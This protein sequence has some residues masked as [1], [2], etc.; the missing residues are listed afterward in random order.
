MK[1]Y[2]AL[3]LFVRLTLAVAV[4]FFVIRAVLNNWAE[5]RS[6]SWDFNPTFLVLSV[7]VFLGGYIFLAWIWGRVLY[8]A[9]HPVS[10][11]AAWDIYFIGNLGRYIPGKV[12]TVA[13]TAYVA[14][15]YGVPAVA[16]GTL[17]VFAQAYSVISS[18]VIFA[19]FFICNGSLLKGIPLEWTAPIFILVLLIFLAPG[20]LGR[21]LN[22][23]LARLGRERSS[24][25]LDTIGALKIMLWYFLSWL[26]FGAAFWLFMIA[27][28]GDRSLQPFFLTGVFVVSNV[29][30]FLAVFT[31]GGLG[32]REG[33]MGLLLAGYIPAGVGILAAFLLR[34]LTTMVELSCVAFVLIRK[35]SLYGKEKTALPGS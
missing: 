17:S 24:I 33:I 25:R 32:V 27:I 21:A 26:V 2:R 14:E 20:N 16:A 28:T 31:P 7:M 15:K 8:S 9:G 13:F 1:G 4:L 11:G 34:L 30:G 22:F 6:Y 29:T 12:W 35:G 23:L 3:S 5:V 10:F 19:L 18:L